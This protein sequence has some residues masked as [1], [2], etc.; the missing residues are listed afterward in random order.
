MNSIRTCLNLPKVQCIEFCLTLSLL[1]NSHYYYDGPDTFQDQVEDINDL[2]HWPKTVS[3]AAYIDDVNA[4]PILIVNGLTK[5]WRCPGFRVCW[6]VAPAPIVKLLGSAGSYLDGGANAPLQRL[7]LPLMDLN[8]IRSDTFALQHHFR[9]KRDYLLKELSVLG[10]KVKLPPTCTF[11]IWADLS[12]L[13]PP[14]NDCLVFLEE[15]T[16][17]QCIVVP[18]VFFDLNP[19]GIRHN[20]KHSACIRNV[21]FSYGPRMEHLLRGIQ[22]LQKMIAYWQQHSESSEMYAQA[23]FN[24]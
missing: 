19:R 17:Y 10:I 5:N 9:M 22:N 16:K 13:P 18:G 6:I 8:F 1:Y 20:I 23:S 11:Y 24:E 21:R 4:D 3:S 14:L 2:K 12:D 15:C 7:A